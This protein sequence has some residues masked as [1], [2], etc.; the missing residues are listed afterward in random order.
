MTGARGAVLAFALLFAFAPTL[1]DLV[2]HALRHPWARANWVFPLLAG[3]AAHAEPDDRAS[4]VDARAGIACVAAGAVGQ[5]VALAGDTI[6]L[7]RPGLVLAAIGLARATGA[8]SWRSAALLAFAIP[9]PHALYELGSPAL[10]TAIATAAAGLAGW[11]GAACTVA[12]DALVAGSERLPLTARDG[13]APLAWL[14][15]GLAWFQSAVCAEPRRAAA[16]RAL[17]SVLAAGALQLALLTA[18]AL[19]LAGGASAASVRGGLDG[20]VW[21]GTSAVALVLV[22][23]SF[24]RH[25]ALPVAAAGSRS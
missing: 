2:D 16:V 13:G 8:A 12:G 22:I 24:A 21:L 1:L 3:V 10:E 9:L 18:A 14:A 11:A 19:A 15:I 4:R 25:D 7:A 20:S 6:R 23:R 17:R 5:L